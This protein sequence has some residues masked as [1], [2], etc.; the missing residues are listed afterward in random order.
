MLAVEH[1]SFRQWT[2]FVA[3][4]LSNSHNIE[5]SARDKQRLSH[6]NCH[7]NSNSVRQSLNWRRSGRKKPAEEQSQW[8]IIIWCQNL[9]DEIGRLRRV[10]YLHF[11]D[12]KENGSLYHIRMEP[13]MGNYL[14]N[15]VSTVGV[16]WLTMGTPGPGNTAIETRANL[17]NGMLL[18][19]LSGRDRYRIDCLSCVVYKRVRQGKK[20]IQNCLNSLSSDRLMH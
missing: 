4:S 20:L 7:S 3:L 13:C 8:Q 16:V 11:T 5:A 2:H 9:C 6:N 12:R 18:Q 17:C 10:P 19:I 15:V 14:A 1:K